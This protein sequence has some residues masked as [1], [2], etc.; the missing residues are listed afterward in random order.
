MGNL[1]ELYA[2]GLGLGRF[3]EKNDIIGD[4]NEK[5]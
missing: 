2:S 1:K 3:E 4:I 5:I